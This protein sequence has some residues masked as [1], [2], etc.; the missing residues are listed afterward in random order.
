[1]PY[2]TTAERIGVQKGIAQGIAQGIAAIIEIKFGKSG[3]PLVER[4]QRLQDA[5][6]LQKLMEKLKRA[7][8]LSDAEQI[9]AAMEAQ[10]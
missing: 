4:T 5:E 10:A 3:K 9:F 6:T 8:S 2:I 1:M 7:Q